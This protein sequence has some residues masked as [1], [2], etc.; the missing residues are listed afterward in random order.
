MYFT[1]CDAGILFDPS[2]VIEVN[3]ITEAP[4]S[5][6]APPPGDDE[7]IVTVSRVVLSPIEVFVKVFPFAPT[8][9]IAGCAN[10]PTDEVSP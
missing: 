7:S 6:L 1:A 10:N 4:I 8:A 3:L 2:E 9:I 5:A